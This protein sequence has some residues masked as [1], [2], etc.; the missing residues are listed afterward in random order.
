[1]LEQW[2]TNQRTEQNLDR[3]SLRHNHDSL[4]AV[5]GNQLLPCCHDPIGYGCQC[6]TPRDYGMQWIAQTICHTLWPV[7]VRCSAGE[8][9]QN[10]QPLIGPGI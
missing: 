7:T 9:G 10:A 6:F 3:H 4:P 5:T 1:V 8:S 2:C